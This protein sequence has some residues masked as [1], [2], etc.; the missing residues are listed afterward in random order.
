M[1]M[2]PPDYDYPPVIPVIE[3]VLSWEEI[4]RRCNIVFGTQQLRRGCSLRWPDR[5]EIWLSQVGFVPKPVGINRDLRIT[6]K[7]QAAVRRHEIA[8]C[9]GW[10]S[11][12]PG[13]IN[14]HVDGER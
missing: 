7:V 8:H 13:A 12:H 10:P 1:L 5:C 4:Q 14:K 9:N 11:G 2:P 6:E 3:H